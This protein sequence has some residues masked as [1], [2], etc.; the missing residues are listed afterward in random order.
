MAWPE[1]TPGAG[2][3]WNSNEGTPW[4]RERLL[5]VVAQSVCAKDENGAISPLDERMYHWPRLWGSDR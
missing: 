2:W 4:N 5:G 3:P 1:L